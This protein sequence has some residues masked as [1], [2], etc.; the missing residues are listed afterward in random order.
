MAPSDKVLKG[1]VPDKATARAHAQPGKAYAV[2]VRGGP[3]ADLVLDLPAGKWRAEWVN[4]KTGAADKAEVL[5]HAGGDR[6]VASP[7]YEQ[8]VALRVVPAK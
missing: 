4:T 8:D 5:D 2:Y 7:P 3:R 6:T 1:G